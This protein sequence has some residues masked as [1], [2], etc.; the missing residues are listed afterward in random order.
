MNKLILLLLPLYLYGIT[1]EFKS[2]KNNQDFGTMICKDSKYGLLCQLDLHNLPPGPHGFHVHQVN[3]CKQHGM[4]AKGHFSLK[5]QKHL[6]PYSPISHLGD[7]PKI[8]ID[9]N[10][11]S[12]SQILAPRLNENILKTHSIIIHELGDNYSDK[13]RPLGGGGKRI[14]CAVYVK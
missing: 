5:H 6:G 14:A 1:Y 3:S 11:S 8:H 7:L 9:I 4:A 10:G 2:T 13:P 12:T